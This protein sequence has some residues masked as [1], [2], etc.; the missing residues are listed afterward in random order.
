VR[1]LAN[2]IVAQRAAAGEPGTVAHGDT[3]SKA[4]RADRTA[5]IRLVAPI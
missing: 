2:R 1:G 4:V 5:A 3:P